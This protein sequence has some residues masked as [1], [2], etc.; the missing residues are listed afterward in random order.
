[1]RV[2]L[3]GTGAISH[4]HA[5]A[6]K[7][8]GYQV[9]ACTDISRE[10]GEKFAAQYGCEFV[11]DFKDLCKH[12][13]ID[14]VDVCTFPDFRLE[15]IEIA[16]QHGKHVQVQKPIATNL[17]TARKMIAAAKA[18]G[19]V[20]GVVSQHRFDDSTIFVKK[21]IESGRLGKILQADAYVKWWRSEQYYSR[22][23]KGSWAVEGGGALIN[24]AVHQVDVLQYLVGNVAEIF[25][26]WQ[27]HAR[28]KIESE[29][30]I[31]TVMRYAG[32]ATGVIQA[33][34]AIW[35]GYSER[36]EIHGTKG[37][38]IFTGDKLTT[39]D[40]E[41]DTG[42]PAPVEKDVMSGSSDPMAIPLTPFER[43]FLDF[44]DACKRGTKPL[45]SGE[46]G[47]RALEVV[48]GAYDSCRKGE[49]V[50]LAS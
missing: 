39:W 24:Q 16:A 7:N 20:L 17:E 47:L 11:A 34:T 12:P 10:Y 13:N 23:I 14:Y 21:A 15:P 43:Q 31:C 18:G 26:F 33:S 19:I 37:T 8:I 38:A 46:E 35:P 9:T 3:I 6:Y 2:G 32:G 27:L 22:P 41:N 25:A 4:K 5:Q 48:L 45:V 49:K 50:K 40:V 44:G 29:D 28:H 42:E 36:I 30:V 1:L